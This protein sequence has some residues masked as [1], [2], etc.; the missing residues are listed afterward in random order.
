MADCSL[1][2]LPLAVVEDRATDA[3]RAR[4]RR[5]QLQGA[6][7]DMVGSTS[8]E[9]TRDLQGAAPLLGASP[10][11]MPGH[12]EAACDA[13]TQA[14]RGGPASTGQAAA[15]TAGTA[16][17]AEMRAV[18]ERYASM[19]GFS[20][21]L[22]NRTTRL[23]RRARRS[24][25]YSCQ[26][27]QQQHAGKSEQTGTNWWAPH[28]PE[29]G[30]ARPSPQHSV[31]QHSRASG[32]PSTPALNDVAQT[33]WHAASEQPWQ[34]QPPPPPKHAQAGQCGAGSQPWLVPRSVAVAS[35]GQHPQHAA[36]PQH[37]PSARLWA[38][39][40]ELSRAPQL[41]ALHNEVEAF[42]RQAMPT[43][44]GLSAHSIASL[45]WQA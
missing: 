11:P 32:H 18:E 8:R 27:Q 31:P 24:Q 25:L 7:Q 39:Q 2:T 22:V 21:G 17:Q 33:T 23:S 16:E 26:K 43:Q 28:A 45:A 3:V 42:A 35:R 10:G 19:K 40:A 14:V 44:V 29:H 6:V 37:T 13:A 4:K 15:G 30:G 20:Q 36:Q 34:Q 38:T 41:S 5:K 12:Q 9:S 1:Q